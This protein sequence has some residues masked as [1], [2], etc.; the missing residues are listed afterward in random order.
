MPAGR[1]GACM[2][3]V[4][5]SVGRWFR[6]GSVVDHGWGSPK[7]PGFK[8]RVVSWREKVFVWTVLYDL[9]LRSNWFLR[10]INWSVLDCNQFGFAGPFSFQVHPFACQF[11]LRF[12]G[13]MLMNTSFNYY[14]YYCFI[15]N[16]LGFF[17][18]TPIDLW[19][20]LNI[21][22]IEGL[23]FRYTVL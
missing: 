7:Y 23:S 17:W 22:S 1:V 13:N 11:Q 14:H 21:L 4:R 10:G 19:L 6:A 9:F 18:V 8:K 2:A 3:R 20:N 12:E 5:C 15:N 16:L